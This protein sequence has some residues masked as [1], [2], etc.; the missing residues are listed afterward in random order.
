M[1]RMH[2]VTRPTR[3]PGCRKYCRSRD[4]QR[5]NSGTERW[6]CR[7]VD[8][9]RPVFGGILNTTNNYDVNPK[10]LTASCAKTVEPIEMPSGS[11]L[12]W[13]QETTHLV[14]FTSTP[15][16]KNTTERSACGE[17]RCGLMPNYFNHLLSCRTSVISPKPAERVNRR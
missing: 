9:F 6:N 5:T 3:R 16:G 15:R 2:Y 14:E 12:A 11:R 7:L 1:R 13:T 10:H 4:C 8:K 17:R